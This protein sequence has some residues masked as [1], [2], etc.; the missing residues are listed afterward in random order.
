DWAQETVPNGG[1][2]NIG[3]YGNMPEASR[4]PTNGWLIVITLNDGGRFEGT[5]WLRWAVGGD[6]T[7]H[8]VTLEFSADGGVTWSNIAT[9]VPAADGAYLWNSVPYGSTMQGVWRIT[10]ESDTNVWDQTDSLFALRNAPITFYVNNGSTAGDVYCSA[11]GGSSNDGLS[12]ASPKLDLQD[13]LDTWDIEPGDTIYVDTGEYTLTDPI[14]I[15]QFDA[16]EATNRVTIQ[17]S[18]NSAAGG[19]VFVK[20]GGGSGIYLNQA[21]G[22]ALR[23]FKVRNANNGVRLYLSAD[24]RAEW[25]RCED[26]GN[27]FFVEQSDRFEALHCV[28]AGNSSK[29]LYV[30]NSDQVTW[31]SGVLWSN[32]YGDA[33]ESSDLGMSHTVIGCWGS[34]AFA[35]WQD[36]SSSLTSDYNAIYLGNGA[37]AAAVLGGVGGGG[38]TRYESVSAW[39]LETD[40]DLHTL[41]VDPLFADAAGYDFH[42]KSTAGRYLPGTGW[43]TDSVSSVLI[44]AGDPASVWTNEPSPNGRRINIGLYGGTAEA[45]RTPTN[46]WLQ[47]ITL[48]DGG[49]IAGT[50][51]VRWVAGGIATGHTVTLRFSSDA[52]DTWSNIASGVSAADGTYVWNTVPFGTTALGLWD[53]TSDSDTNIT[54]T[55]DELFYLRNGGTLPYYVNDSYTNG[56]VYCTAPGASTNLGLR[57]MEP[58]SSIQ[59]ILDTYDLEPGDIIYVD[60]GEYDL[61]SDILIGDLD[62]GDAT[63]PVVFLGSTNYAAG[64]TVLDRQVAGEEI[65][66]IHLYQTVGIELRDLIV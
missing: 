53:I 9:N 10:D 14:T 5:N 6:S 2:I 25:V 56:D 49:S 45:S 30:K 55:S 41:A 44:D 39:S 65:Y 20:Y 17:G 4:T 43:V 32:R 52:G 61:D 13:L 48:N 50:V 59:E 60:T 38:T 42:L 37:F 51:T 34:G 1:R 15:D 46:G 12:P 7:G 29:G 26:G 23:H 3:L 36:S 22:V 18:T 64:G 28:A 58:K 11:P 33:V 66:G 57:P 16:G 62:A 31:S 47:I 40:Q 21:V 35:H 24:C 27:G 8:T 54:D 19:T 63:N